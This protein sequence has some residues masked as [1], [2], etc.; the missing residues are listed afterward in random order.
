M[1][2]MKTFL[3]PGTNLF[4]V[5][6]IMVSCCTP[7]QKKNNIITIAWTG[8]LSSEPPII[9]ICLRRSRFSYDLIAE[10]GDFVVNIPTEDQ[11]DVLD[12]CGTH[13]GSKV[14]KFVECN[15]TPVPGKKVK[16]PLILE[17][18]VNLECKLIKIIKDYSESHHLFMGKVVS[19]AIDQ[20]LAGEFNVKKIKPIAYAERGYWG[21][22]N[23]LGTFGCSK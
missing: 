23:L 22:S 20:E 19:V 8:V 6:A 13:T 14:D 18:P 4:P 15:L 3:K 12:Y 11:V 9:G 17:C 7:N 2:F 1:A 5:P 10:T 21:L 16:A